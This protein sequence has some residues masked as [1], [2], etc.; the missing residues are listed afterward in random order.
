MSLPLFTHLH[1]HLPKGRQQLREGTQG[2]RP[3]R[4]RR[5]ALPPR[6][7][8]AGLPQTTCVWAAQESDTKFST[9]ANHLGIWSRQ[10]IPLQLH[11]LL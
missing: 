1:L 10:N 5:E 3:A 11:S 4:R 9:S 8:T 6:S 2:E 7:T